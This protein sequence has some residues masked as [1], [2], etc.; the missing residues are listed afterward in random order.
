MKFWHFNVCE[1]VL[2]FLS[3]KTKDTSASSWLFDF[4][5]YFLAW[6]K[7]EKTKHVGGFIGIL[8]F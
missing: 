2:E 3:L 5:S 4:V 1:Y 7:N 8:A 6:Y